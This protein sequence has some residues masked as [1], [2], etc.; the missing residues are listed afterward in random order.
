MHCDDKRTLF[1]LK[2]GIEEAW[3]ELK[4]ADFNDE[5]LRTELLECVNNYYFGSNADKTFKYRFV[6]GSYEASIT[7]NQES[8]LPTELSIK[9][10]TESGGYELFEKGPSPLLGR[11]VHV[12][13]IKAVAMSVLL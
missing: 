6:N 11:A 10:V 1:A 7:Y 12:S 2:K 8:N 4:K 5:D 3:N 9:S 13:A